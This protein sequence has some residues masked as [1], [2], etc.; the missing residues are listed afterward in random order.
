MNS[1]KFPNMFTSSRTKVVADH[2]AT[3]QN[4]LLLLKSERGDFA[5]DPEFGIRLKRFTYDQND[6]ILKDMI[7]DE[8]YT[9]IAVFM[10]QLTVDRKDITI[11]QDRASLYVN[12]RA[13]NNLDFTTD[14]YN[15]AL[16][17]GEE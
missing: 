17:Q 13:I 2:D 7:I 8:I 9:K 5:D 12:I 10:P 1:I 11:T 4:L 3:T 14:L 6:Y 16:L 15:L